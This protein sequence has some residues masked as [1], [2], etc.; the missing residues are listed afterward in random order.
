LWSTEVIERIDRHSVVRLLRWALSVIGICLLTCGVLYAQDETAGRDR[1]G[2]EVADVTMAE[3]RSHGWPAPRGAK[4]VSVKKGGPA[5]RAG[6]SR[7]DILVSADGREIANAASFRSLVAGIPGGTSLQLRLLRDRRERLVTLMVA[8]EA[9][10]PKKVAPPPTIDRSKQSLVVSVDTGGH[11]NL[12]RGLNFTPD[13]KYLISGGD[14]KVI[15][16]WDVATG[17]TDRIIRGEISAGREGQILAM[18]LSPDGALLAASGWITGPDHRGHLIRLYDF[19]TGNLIGLLAGHE[20]RI[21]SLAFS[22]DG[23]Y[24]V[25]GA[26]D[27]VAIIWDVKTRQSQHVLRGHRAEVYAV[28]FVPG[29]RVVTGSYDATLKLWRVADGSEI[30]TLTGHQGMV[31]TIAI[32]PKTGTIASGSRTG[33]LILW[34]S[35]TGELRKKLETQE[36]VVGKLQ[37][38]PDGARLLTTAAEGRE[39]FVQKV[40]DTQTGRVL[41]TYKGHDNTVGAAAISPDQRLA[42]TAG[43]KDNEIHIWDLNTGKIVNSAAGKPLILRGV[44]APVFATGWQSDTTYVF[45]GAVSD[46]ATHNDRGALTYRL[47]LPSAV[48]KL[49]EPERLSVEAA[50]EAVRAQPTLGSLSL[51]HSAGGRYGHDAV[52]TIERDGQAIATLTRDQTDGYGHVAYTFTPDAQRVVS[53]GANGHLLAYDLA[54][55]LVGRFVGHEGVIWAVACS[56]DGRYLISGGGDQTIRIWNLAS[57]ELIATLLQGRDEEWVMWTPQGYYTGS[58]GADKIVGWQI[59]HGFDHAADFVGAEQLRQHL[60]RPDIVERALILGSATQAVRES[61]GTTFTL[62]DLLARSV[63]QFR[64]LA[65][66]TAASGGRAEVRIAIGATPDPIKAIRVQVN[67]RQIEEHTPPVGSGGFQPGERKLD[68]P[69]AGG[70]NDVRITLTN[71]IGEKAETATIVHE[72]EGLLDKRGTLYIVAIGVDKYPGLGNICG[73]QG[74][75]SCDLDYSS[76]DAR[77]FVDVVERRMGA[78]HQSVVKRVLVNNADN[79]SDL[80]TAANILDAVTQLQN[81]TEIDTVVVSIAGHGYND[82]ANYRFLATNAEWTGGV[83]RG[84]TVV[85]WQILQEAI[86]T[87]KGRRILFVDTCHSGNAYNPRLGNAAYHANIVAYS[88]SRFDQEALEDPKLGHGLFTYAVTEGLDGRAAMKSKNQVSAKDLADYV[89]KRVDQLARAMKARQEP[90]YFK[91]RDA[92]DYVLARF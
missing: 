13:G 76:A 72:G 48:G 80:P 65:P 39:L 45:W 9:A 3:A 26:H 18:A 20:N 67:G 91:G 75:A 22:S 25:S 11:R 10:L 16:V 88:A 50:L 68:V 58:P 47:R 41:A 14:D 77:R 43:G 89:L 85:S 44:G 34:D 84:S 8:P 31:E 64:I 86:E 37:F 29:G 79:S 54:G 90:Q 60:H 24:L 17:K 23:Q 78:T 74:N 66:S 52:L 19:R 73:A 32:S 71:A 59:N 49:S 4:A 56:K 27:N 5:A 6:I 61:L 40:W 70:R 46:Y 51:S 38:S 2:V 42:A 83:L 69:L 33:E 35:E 30:T 63:P 92:E 53:G 55:K 62:T 28:A 7:N 36:N 57:Y 87:A 15:R 82:G 81:A 1:S 21:A 12:I